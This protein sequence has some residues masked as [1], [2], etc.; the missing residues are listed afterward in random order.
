MK[1]LFVAVFALALTASGST[2]AGNW[3]VNY[4]KSTLGFTVQWSNQPFSAN[5]KTWK[6]DI[7]FDPADLAH[8]HVDV[9][10]E[11]ASEASD[12]DEFDSGIRGALGFQTQQFPTAHFV[13]ANF[14]HK[15][16]N[17]YVA[18]GNLTIRG[19]SKPV[20]LPF[21]LAITGKSAHMTGTAQ[22]MRL[23]YGVGTEGEWAADTPVSHAVT[24]TVDLTAT[25]G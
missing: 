13:A 3:T 24:V 4:A 18:K 9:T 6:A 1:K 15:A 8:A 14:T 23:D 19:I 17:N 11:M 5:F 16:G 25:R 7:Q 2:F 12:E 20:T 22:V 10:I 21:T